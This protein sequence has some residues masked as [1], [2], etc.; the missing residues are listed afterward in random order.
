MSSLFLYMSVYL[1]HSVL[2]LSSSSQ[3]CHQQQKT[4]PSR[5]SLPWN[6]QRKLNANTLSKQSPSL[7]DAPFRCIVVLVAVASSKDKF[8]FQTIT[9]CR[10]KNTKS[11]FVRTPPL[12]I[13]N[14]SPKISTFHS[15][16]HPTET[17]LLGQ[18]KSAPPFQKR[19]NKNPPNS[20]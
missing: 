14:A 11:S 13:S 9:K 18:E 16:F 10:K 1:L 19:K 7:D 2:Y 8:P 17:K 5:Q 6:N 12:P 15:D 20:P 3:K 4:V